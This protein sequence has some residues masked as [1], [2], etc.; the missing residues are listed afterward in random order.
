MA[1]YPVVQVASNMPGCTYDDPEVA[2]TP[3]VVSVPVAAVAGVVV[4]ASVA[5]P[6]AAVDASPEVVSSQ[7]APPHLLVFV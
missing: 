1:G 3:E 2:A 5:V 6:V 4:V 7:I